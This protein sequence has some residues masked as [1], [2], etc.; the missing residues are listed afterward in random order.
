MEKTDLRVIRNELIGAFMAL[1]EVY[2]RDSGT[3]EKTE[4]IEIEI[5]ETLI[6]S[7][8]RLEYHYREDFPEMRIQKKWNSEMK[9]TYKLL[10]KYAEPNDQ[11][12]NWLGRLRMKEKYDYTGY[13][14]SRG[15]LGDLFDASE[16]T[17]KRIR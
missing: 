2:V 15:I 7:M 17:L 11:F 4:Y 10:K 9:R 3:K 6:N 13:T 12:Y 14:K 5:I 8:K 16:K 1:D